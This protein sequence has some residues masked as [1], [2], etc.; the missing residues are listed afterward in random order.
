M[1][2]TL[3]II[4]LVVGGTLAAVVVIGA[5][6]VIS[7]AFGALGVAICM[8]AGRAGVN[9]ARLAWLWRTRRMH[10]YDRRFALCAGVS[11]ALIA[12]AMLLA[13]SGALHTAAA[14]AGF[15]SCF[16]PLAFVGW[17]G[18][19]RRFLRR[20]PDGDAARGGGG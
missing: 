16:A 6:F 7:P 19:E 11:A 20:L 3:I 13:G 18:T 2:K 1:P 17:L 4:G 9:L 10:P 14:L 5:L 8:G 12:A 15:Y